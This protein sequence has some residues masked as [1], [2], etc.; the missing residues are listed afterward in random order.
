MPAVVLGAVALTALFFLAWVG[1]HIIFGGVALILPFVFFIP[2]Y[3]NCLATALSISFEF[4]IWMW[5]IIVL[6]YIGGT[7]IHPTS[8]ITGCI[9]TISI[10][11]VSS[12][13]VFEDTFKISVPFAVAVIVLI[14]SI[15]IGAVIGAWLAGEDKNLLAKFMV[16]DNPA[17]EIFGAVIG[18]VQAFFAAGLIYVLMKS[19]DA[20]QVADKLEDVFNNNPQF[21]SLLIQSVVIGAIAAVAVIVIGFVKIHKNNKAIQAIKLD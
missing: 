1:L 3:L 17:A 4:A 2:A 10:I 20:I 16:E 13:C 11:T 12:V 8:Q 9:S 5:L 7:F 15:I 21:D 14:V 6:L 18:A 19:F